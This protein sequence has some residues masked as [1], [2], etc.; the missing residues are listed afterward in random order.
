MLCLKL[1]RDHSSFTQAQNKQVE[2]GGK[3]I[4]KK[5]INGKPMSNLLLYICVEFAPFPRSTLLVS[6]IISA[7]DGNLRKNFH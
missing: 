2:M 3:E 4:E 7:E 6:P 1:P 5:Q